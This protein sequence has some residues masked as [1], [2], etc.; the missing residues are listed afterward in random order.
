MKII[1]TGKSLEFLNKGIEGREGSGCCL[2]GH[3][4][5]FGCF[6]EEGG[7][8]FDFFLIMVGGAD[9]GADLEDPPI[10]GGEGGIFSC[11][12]WGYGLFQG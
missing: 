8:S 3:E 5:L 6:H 7:R 11:K 12:E 10:N 4:P 1:G 2:L 9:V